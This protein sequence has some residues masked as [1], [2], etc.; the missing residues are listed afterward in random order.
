M[1]RFFRLT[2]AIVA[3]VALVAAC[4]GTANGPGVATLDDPSA[5][6][7]PGASPA[8]SAMTPQDAALAFARCMRENGVDMP[9]PK[10]TTGTDGGVSIDQQGGAPVSKDKMEAANKV[11]QHFMAAA[12]PGGPGGHI[13]AEDLDKLLQF[14]KCM[15]EHG[16]DMPDPNG[17]GGIVFK[18]DNSG[19][20]TVGKGI[21]SP[22]DPKFQAAQTACKE[23]LPGKPS[24]SGGGPAPAGGSNS[25]PATN[26]ANQ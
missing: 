21:G 15:R 9:D 1:S 5:S 11:C 19:S 22:D 3:L 14:A 16:I 10:V 26:P 2:L 7:S 4:S 13:S 24:L 23:F 8:A 25:G 20:N 18:V 12:G 6:G 17:D